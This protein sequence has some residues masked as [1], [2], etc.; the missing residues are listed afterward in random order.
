MLSSPTEAS[1]WISLEPYSVGRD[2]MDA[3]SPDTGQGST[4]QQV[5]LFH[6]L[7]LLEGPYANVAAALLDSCLVK[8]R[9]MW[10]SLS[11]PREA[12]RL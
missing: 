2:A 4:A 3:L 11:R 5:V 12:M 1:E 10:Y 9:S 6:P 8:L 7:S